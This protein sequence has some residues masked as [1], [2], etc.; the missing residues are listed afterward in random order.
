MQK[1]VILCGF[2]GCGKTTV[3]KLV[4]QA[5]ERPFLDLDAYICAREGKT[6][7]EIFDA[8]GEDG[9]REREHNAC[10]ALE[11]SQGQVIAAG[12]GTLA[13]ARNVEA[14]K[15][16]GVIVFL[17]VSL[18]TIAARLR[19]DDTRPLLNG[20]GRE[21][22]MRTLYDARR[23]LYLGAADIVVTADWTPEETARQVVQAAASNT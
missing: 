23:P 7:A 15:I 6:V 4:A 5:L 2:M 3:G 11:K 20:P 10:A 18:E 1:N 19:G 8:F 21:E 9:F 14:L 12:G 22:A 13:F 16:N 17:D